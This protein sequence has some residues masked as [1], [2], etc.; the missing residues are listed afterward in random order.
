MDDI[1]FKQGGGDLD[2]LWSR[3]KVGGSSKHGPTP[4]GVLVD[5]DLACGGEK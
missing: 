4:G 2:G 3:L 5:R 1:A